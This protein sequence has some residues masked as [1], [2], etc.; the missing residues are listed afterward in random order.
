MFQPG[1]PAVVGGGGA[2]FNFDLPIIIGDRFSD[3][4]PSTMV[5]LI[6]SLGF[7]V[8]MQSSPLSG[9]FTVFLPLP[10]PP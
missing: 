2:I 9:L 5:I 8:T 10:R 4:S 6:V 1:A 7:T 3:M